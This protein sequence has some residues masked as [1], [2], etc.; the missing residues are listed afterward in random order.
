MARLNFRIPDQGTRSPSIFRPFTR[1]QP[2]VAMRRD[3]AERAAFNG[4]PARFAQTW[5]LLI[6]S[7]MRFVLG[8][9]NTV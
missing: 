3:L 1:G 2:F 8:S 9:T 5:L 6:I 7:T 4:G